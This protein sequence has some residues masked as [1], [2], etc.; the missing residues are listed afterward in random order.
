MS[1]DKPFVEQVVRTL[2]QHA[3][4]LDEVTAARLAAIR[5]SALNT[6]PGRTRWLSV[7][8]LSAIA[9]SVFALA[10]LFNQ[11]TDAPGIDP[12]ALEQVAQSQDQELI[13]ELDFYNWLDSMQASS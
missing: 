9:A 5:R 7:A 3:E 6:R 8:A 13:E 2:D 12:D 4:A 1:G 10:L 11:R